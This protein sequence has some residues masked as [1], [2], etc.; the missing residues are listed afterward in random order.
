MRW[1]EAVAFV[2][3]AAAVGL[4]AGEVRAQVGPPGYSPY[5]NLVRPGS[6]GINYYGLVRPQVDIRNDVRQLQQTTT[7]IQTGVS[8]IV[9][10]DLVTGH[11]SGYMNFSHYYGGALRGGIAARGPVGGLA[12]G[13]ARPAAVQPP[14][15]P[16]GPATPSGYRR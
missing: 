3:A 5:L 10:G 1:R 15:T 6:P 12:V 11:Q 13:A 4:G 16:Q 7:S 9:A 14:A 2:A 8:Q